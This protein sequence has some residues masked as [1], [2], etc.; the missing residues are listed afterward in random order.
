MHRLET[1]VEDAFASRSAVHVIRSG[2]VLDLYPVEE[3]EDEYAQRLGNVPYTTDFFSALGT[4]LARRMWGAA[5]N[6][7]QVIAMDC[8]GVLWNGCCADAQPVVVDDRR[9]LLQNAVLSQR[10]T[11]ML[12]CL[13]STNR[14]QD[15]WAAFERAPGMPIQRDDFVAAAI[16]PRSIAES[17]STLANELGFGLETFIFMSADQQTCSEVEAECPEVLTL[18]APSD[19]EEIPSWLKHVWAFD[20]PLSQ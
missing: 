6:Q 14:E 3:Y 7:Y 4:M 20:R 12:L 13:C 10:D 17:L 5:E 11:G 15:V 9:R 18:Q 16:G 1:K 8:D 19:S 2:E